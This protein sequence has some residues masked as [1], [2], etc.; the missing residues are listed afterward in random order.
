MVAGYRAD[1]MD[2][3]A[4]YLFS[5]DQPIEFSGTTFLIDF[6]V[7]LPPIKVMM[8]EKV[9]YR[10]DYYTFQYENESSPRTG[11]SK[12]D[13]LLTMSQPSHEVTATAKFAFGNQKFSIGTAKY[14]TSPRC[15]LIRPHSFRRELVYSGVAR[16]VISLLYRE[17]YGNIS[18]P[19]F[20]QELHYDLNEGNEI[21][22]KGARFKVLNADNVGITY[23]VV[24]PFED[25]AF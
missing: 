23:E 14:F 3:V 20:S 8:R 6:T 10:P 2:A 4:G 24:K 15:T 13:V 18:R 12:P 22:Y 17:H 7:T 25:L 1:V 11:F 5:S 19:K 16:G 21:G 9:S